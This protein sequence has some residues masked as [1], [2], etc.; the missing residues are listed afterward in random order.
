[1]ILIMYSKADQLKAI[2]LF[3]QYNRSWSA[4]VHDLGYPSVAGLKRWVKSYEE[5]SKAFTN[6]APKKRRSKYNSSQRQAA[7]DYYFKHG[8]KI[9]N[10]VK[11]L[12]YP[13]REILRRWI[14]KDPRCDDET[15]ARHS[16]S[17]PSTPTS[18]RV[19][20]V[21]ALYQRKDSAQ[22]IAE[23]YHVSRERLYTWKD[24]LFG[25]QFP[26]KGT[27]FKK[28]N[29]ISN[30]TSNISEVGK[31]QQ[32][33]HE[34]E[35]QNDILVQVNDLLKKDLGIDYHHLTNYEKMIVINALR[36]KYTLK[37]LLDLLEI[38]KSSYF[39]Q[40]KVQ[41]REDKYK[42]VRP[43]LKLIFKQNYSCY[44]YRRLKGELADEGVNISEKVVRRLMDEERIVVK[45]TKRQKY[46]S[47]AG[48]LT[49]AVPNLLKRNFKAV[50]PNTKWLTDISEFII[51]AGKVYLSP[52]IDC[53]DG[54]VV[55]WSIGT[56]PNAQLVNTMLKEGA[57]V[58]EVK[59][60]PI[61]HS[62]RGSHY[63]WPE[64]INLM[65]SFG[66]TRSMSKK[67]CTPDNSA[68]EGFFGRLKTEFFY[69][70]SWK[71]ISQKDFIKELDTYLN[72][73]NTKRRK[74]SLGGKSPQEYR[75][76]V[77]S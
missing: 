40:L 72:W 17:K 33:I 63:R 32:Q 15:K 27:V 6:P 19:K 38:A 48:E 4:V 70:Q 26:A 16:V 47:Y 21:E 44:G 34:L 75:Q 35:L 59:E 64:W 20:A 74:N 30:T 46:N 13:C 76:I 10:T 56:S 22:K 71:H 61:V 11:V 28:P 49:P 77:L 58:L 8:R 42:E 50:R 54:Q 67:G 14:I 69:N 25:R 3:Y 55:S 7:V 41:G 12:G 23:N 2:N 43:R 37:E 73:Y 36:S 29:T 9:A 53:F 31:L 62:D 57:K 51:P 1:M 18:I 66:L 24:D 39:Y 45:V 5:N 65:K 60:K 68:C 52:L